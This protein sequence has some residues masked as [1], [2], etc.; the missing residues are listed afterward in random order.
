MSDLKR[1]GNAYELRCV[2]FADY[3]MT[4]YICVSPPRRRTMFNVSLRIDSF[5]IVSNRIVSNRVD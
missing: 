4:A 1:L 2:D 3:R 5:H